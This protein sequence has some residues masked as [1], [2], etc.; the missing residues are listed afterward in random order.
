MPKGFQKGNDLSKGR[1]KGSVNVKNQQW[2]S[3]GE[4]LSQQG[5]ERM[6]EYLQ[7]TDPDKY[8]DT[9]LKI[10][11]YF[12]PKLAR[13]ESKISGVVEVKPILNGISKNNSNSKGS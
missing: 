1:P 3:I 8:A 10:L 7:K 6:L 5:A 2:D 4:F 11:E 9:Y 12:K 13:T